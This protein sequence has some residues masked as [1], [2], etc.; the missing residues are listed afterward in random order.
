M[1]PV[2]HLEIPLIQIPEPSTR[3]LFICS[4]EQQTMLHSRKLIAIGSHQSEDKAHLID[5]LAQQR[6]RLRCQYR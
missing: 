5:S 3:I 6:V 4:I 2:N 1:I